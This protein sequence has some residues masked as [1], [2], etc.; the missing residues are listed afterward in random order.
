M[1]K[2]YALTVGLNAVDP[3]HYQGWSGPLVACEADATDMAN[4]LKAQA[5]TVTTLLTK[6]ATRAAVRSKLHD[7]AKQSKSGDIFVYT[8]SSHG[9]HLPDLNGDEDDGQDETLCMYD[10]EIIDDELYQCFSEFAAGVRVLVLSDSCHSGTVTRLSRNGD[11]LALPP[12]E[13]PAVRAMPPT[14]ALRTYQ[15]NRQL[16]DELLRNPALKQ[17]R[18][19][20][21]AAVLSISGCM[22]NQTSSDG[23]FNGLFTA[24]LLRVWNAGKFTGSYKRFWKQIVSRMPSDQTPNFF[25]ANDRDAAFER[26]TPF[27]IEPARNRSPQHAE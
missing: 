16:Y 17:S 15:A 20:V 24:T 4:L 8:N 13:G 7:A 14:V 19:A 6:Q 3:Q 5:F 12:T 22:D 23:T 26:E 25:W 9:G 2:G 10:G 21:K 18:E 11:I 1:P 27:T